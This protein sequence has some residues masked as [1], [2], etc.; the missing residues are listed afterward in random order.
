VES[1]EKVKAKETKRRKK[2][3]LSRGPSDKWRL[4]YKVGCKIVSEAWFSLV[5]GGEVRY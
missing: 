5:V 3:I 4:R 2:E 1:E